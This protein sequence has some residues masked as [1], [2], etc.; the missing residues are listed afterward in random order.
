[1]KPLF[2]LG[3][4]LSLAACSSPSSDTAATDAGVLAHNDFES[5]AGWLPDESVLTKDQARSGKYA[6]MVDPNH[7]FSLTYNTL[8]G[9]LSE[10]K[11][12]GL[13][14]EA[15]VYLPDDKATAQLGMQVVDPDKNN[16]PTFSDGVALAEVVKEYKQWTKVSKEIV[17]PPNA[18]YNQRVKIFLWRSNA[19]SPVYLDDLTIKVLE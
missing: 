3:L 16:E 19:A 15:W 4:A 9:N 14:V 7:E 2:Y 5:L 6:I 18:T 11:P 13:L 17:L 8:L 10:H 12:R 1:M